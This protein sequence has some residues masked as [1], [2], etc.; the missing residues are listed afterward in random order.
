MP[1]FA[2][3]FGLPVIEALAVG[4]PVIASDLPAHREVAGDL[5]VYRDPADG[6]G[7][8][9]DICMFADG[10]A[11][12]A[13]TRR[14]VLAYRPGVEAKPSGVRVRN[15]PAVCE[16]LM[17]LAV[18]PEFHEDRVA[19]FQERF[20]G[21]WVPKFGQRAAVAVYVWHVL[22][23]SRLIDWLIRAFLWGDPL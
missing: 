3:G 19:D 8:L 6:P 13:E 5:A 21:L 16:W 10:S 17:C 20:N 7:W 14:R 11:A 12:A 22:R 9:T 1:S 18:D 15:V 4:T 23:Q 2:E